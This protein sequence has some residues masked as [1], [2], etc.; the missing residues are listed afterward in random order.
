MKSLPDTI[1]RC[2]VPRP[3]AK[4]R[5]ICVPHAGAGASIYQKWSSLLPETIEV[6]ALQLPGREERLAE[7]PFIHWQPMQESIYGALKRLPPGP[8]A[9]FGHSLGAL[10][11][12][13]AAR[14]L[15]L[16]GK[17]LKHLFVSGR[18]WP[19]ETLEDKVDSSQL[20]D[21]GLLN[22]FTARY[23]AQGP[24]ME[25]PEV[26]EMVLPVLRADFSLLMSCP[27]MRAS[28][29]P[30]PIT[31]FSGSRDPGTANM[32]LHLWQTETEAEFSHHVIPG[33]HLF[34]ME[35]PEEVLQHIRITLENS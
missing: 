26:R 32:N 14:H 28:P 13:D 3:M 21:D 12:L 27:D 24:A 19:G 18:H 4:I 20:S 8:V 35:Q 1:L 17:R 33:G 29:L 6:L 16:N 11:A 9:L 2:P 23:G 30:C 15:S 22:L 5:L 7:S 10:I 31:V 25:N 34:H